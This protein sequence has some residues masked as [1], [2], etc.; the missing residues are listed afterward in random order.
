[1]SALTVTCSLASSFKIHSKSADEGL[2]G[3]IAESWNSLGAGTG[4]AVGV[5]LTP[6]QVGPA[7]SITLSASTAKL[8]KGVEL[9]EAANTI[10]TSLGKC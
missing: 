7:T 8:S 10:R 9:G 1:M 5:W 2:E 3:A 4:G 6:A